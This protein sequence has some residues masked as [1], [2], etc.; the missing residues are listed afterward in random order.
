MAKSEQRV[1]IR[2]MWMK[3]LGARR[4]HIKL[5]R[6]LGDD[7]YGPAAIERWPARLREC[8]LSYADHSRSDRLATDISEC[9]RTF[10]DIFPF[11]SA[12]MQSKHFR[13]AH[14]TI[15]EILQRGLGFK[16]FSR[17]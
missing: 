15:M 8:D 9:L 1:V 4:I 6:V 10:L 17:R 5:S 3:R 7:C 14:G 2:F 11:A 16:T 13:I 12:N